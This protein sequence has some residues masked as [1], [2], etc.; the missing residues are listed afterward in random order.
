M[1]T[2]Y[3]AVIKLLTLLQMA[4]D[5]QPIIK[6]CSPL[7]PPAAHLMNLLPIDV[8]EL[9]ASPLTQHI[10]KAKSNYCYQ[11]IVPSANSHVTVG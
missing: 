1:F 7:P 6:F 2:L 3:A 10:L 9:E 5:A 4:R 11:V 8:Y